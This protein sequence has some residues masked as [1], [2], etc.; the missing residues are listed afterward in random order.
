M[1]LNQE[2]DTVVLGCVSKASLEA[3]L[4]IINKGLLKR[5]GILDKNITLAN[6]CTVKDNNQFFSYRLDNATTKRIGTFIELK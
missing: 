4:W 1:S 3:D 5:A 2:T 6:F